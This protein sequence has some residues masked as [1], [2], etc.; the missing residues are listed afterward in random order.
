MQNRCIGTC[1]WYK[2]SRIKRVKNSDIK[3]SNLNCSRSLLIMLLIALT[4]SWCQLQ[5]CQFESFPLDKSWTMDWLADLN[6]TQYYTQIPHNPLHAT[7][8]AVIQVP[9]WFINIYLFLILR[10]NIFHNGARE[11]GNEKLT[12]LEKPTHNTTFC[13]PLIFLWFKKVASF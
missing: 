13:S 1:I 5:K 11:K 7:I 9:L 3:T 6:K 10:F 2:L 8:P 12:W 4:C